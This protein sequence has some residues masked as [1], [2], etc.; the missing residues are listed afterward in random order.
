MAKVG[1][2]DQ[3][4]SVTQDDLVRIIITDENHAADMASNTEGDA[5]DSNCEQL[6]FQFT[7]FRSHPYFLLFYQN[8][9]RLIILGI[10]TYVAS[11]PSHT[12]NI[13]VGNIAIQS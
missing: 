13:S 6:T 11:I 1:D 2:L 4:T 3:S 10:L 8:L 12:Y 5:V 7:K 9:A